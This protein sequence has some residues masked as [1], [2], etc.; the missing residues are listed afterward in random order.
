MYVSI[1]CQLND[2]DWAET[3]RRSQNFKNH[4][5]TICAD[6][7]RCGFYFADEVGVQVLEKSQKIAVKAR[8]GREASPSTASVIGTSPLLTEFVDAELG[9]RAFLQTIGVSAAIVSY[10]HDTGDVGRQAFLVGFESARCDLQ[11]ARSLV[12]FAENAWLQAASSIF[13]EFRLFE[14]A[15]DQQS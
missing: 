6:V 8:P 14:Q 7:S 12:A 9:W 13:Q 11:L 4:G 15:L 10:A 3:S 2:I 1:V 5:G